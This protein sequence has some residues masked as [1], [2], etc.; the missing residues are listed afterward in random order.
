MYNIDT[1][2]QQMFWT[3]MIAG[4]VIGLAP[5]F[6]AKS[7]GRNFILWWLYGAGFFIVALPHSF[8]IKPTV[9]YM[10]KHGMKKCPF[11]AELINEE[12]IVCKHCRKE[13]Q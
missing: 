2:M 4:V 13:I 11:C 5:A 6:I 3:S 7:K 8:L 12:A 9:E 10:L 1:L